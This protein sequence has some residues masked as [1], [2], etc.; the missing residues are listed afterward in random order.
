MSRKKFFSTNCKQITVFYSTK[1]YALY[2]F[3]KV[4]QG[5][6]IC[7]KSVTWLCVTPIHKINNI[8]N[9]YSQRVETKSAFFVYKLNKEHFLSRFPQ[10]PDL[11]PVIRSSAIF[12]R[13]D[14][15]V[16]I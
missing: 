5:T 4:L 3:F 16:C 14:F 7:V 11:F 15:T 2:T 13:N 9:N 12:K 1:E 8:D 6:G 10:K